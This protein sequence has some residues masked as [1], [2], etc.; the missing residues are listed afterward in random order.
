MEYLA[1]M[2]LGGTNETDNFKVHTLQSIKVVQYFSLEQSIGHSC[3][4]N[5]TTHFE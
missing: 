5:G 2:G 3:I 4:S 1:T